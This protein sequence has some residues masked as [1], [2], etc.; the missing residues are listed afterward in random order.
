[1]TATP[2]RPGNSRIHIPAI[3][4]GD[5]GDNSAQAIEI[6]IRSAK[7]LWGE[8]QPE[9]GSRAEPAFVDRDLP[10][11]R[12]R[13][14]SVPVPEIP[15]L[16]ASHVAVRPNECIGKTEIASASDTLPFQIE[17]AE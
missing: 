4:P 16:D 1:M 11:A 17:R 3:S 8:S 2:A 7:N 12:S 14:A 15:D 10:F 13:A 9:S 5:N 6:P